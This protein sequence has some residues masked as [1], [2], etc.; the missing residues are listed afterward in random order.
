MGSIDQGTK[1]KRL[2][3]IPYVFL[4]IV[5]DLILIVF[6]TNRN[7]YNIEEVK[8]RLKIGYLPIMH[9][10]LPLLVHAQSNGNLN[11]SI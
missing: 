11:I 9:A 5:T 3:M 1:M 2:K 7:D 8:P 10:A 4:I 6:V